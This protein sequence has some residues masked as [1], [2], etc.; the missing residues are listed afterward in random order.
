MNGETTEN[1]FEVTVRYPGSDERRFV[2]LRLSV[3]W[4]FEKKP[5]LYVGN[6]QA[7]PLGEVVDPNDSVI[8]GTYKDYIVDSI[9][10]PVF[11]FAHIDED[12]CMT[13]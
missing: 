9:F 11:K 5:C 6:S 7:G 8:E 1:Y 4:E 2:A 3:T 13:K 12:N 10:S